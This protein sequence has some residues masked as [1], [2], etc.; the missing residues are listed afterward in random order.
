ML[1]GIRI[2]NFIYNKE[3]IIDNPFKYFW[4]GLSF[5][6]LILNYISLIYPLDEITFIFILLFIFILIPYKSIS[7]IKFSFNKYYL[8]SLLFLVLSHSWINQQILMP[9][10]LGYHLNMVKWNHDFG[11]I[12]GLVNINDRFGFNSSFWVLSA[13]FDNFILQDKVISALNI[14]IL[15][16][17]SFNLSFIFSQKNSIKLKILIFTS[18]CYISTKLNSIEINSLSSDLPMQTYIILTAIELTKEEKYSFHLAII[19]SSV[20]FTIKLSGAFFLFLFLLLV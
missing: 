8:F 10:T 17:L 6:F 7:K 2:Y 5:L 14:S 15:T 3:N 16:I 12:K 11:V 20:L 19:Y 9:D 13:I 1:F 18:F 4:L